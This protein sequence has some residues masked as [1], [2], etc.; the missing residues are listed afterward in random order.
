MAVPVRGHVSAAVDVSVQGRTAADFDEPLRIEEDSHW[1]TEQRSVVY[2][3]HR[4]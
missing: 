4:L 3:S 2:R 1:L